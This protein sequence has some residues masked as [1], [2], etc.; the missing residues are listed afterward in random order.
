MKYMYANNVAMG[1]RKYQTIDVTLPN[2]EPRKVFISPDPESSYDMMYKPLRMD[3]TGYGVVCES[4]EN[5]I[6]FMFQWDCD[7]HIVENDVV[8]PE[9]HKWTP[10]PF[11]CTKCH[12]HFITK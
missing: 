6:K 2:G 1:K 3:D 12:K 11:K 9:P 8:S 4:L 10:L 5:A 7:H